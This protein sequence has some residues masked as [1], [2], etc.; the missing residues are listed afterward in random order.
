[1]GH[2]EMGGMTMTSLS[3]AIIEGRG[4]RGTSVSTPA[5]LPFLSSPVVYDAYSNLSIHIPASQKK[6]KKGIVACTSSAHSLLLESNH[7]SIPSFK[8]S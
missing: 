1:M 8:K 7:I 4:E 5:A 3:A 2:P 6:G